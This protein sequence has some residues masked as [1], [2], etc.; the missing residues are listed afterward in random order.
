M[1]YET[2]LFKKVILKVDIDG[3]INGILKNDFLDIWY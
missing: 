2:W 3:K 1:S